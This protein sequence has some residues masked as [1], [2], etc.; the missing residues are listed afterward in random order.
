MDYLLRHAEPADLEHVTEIYRDSVENG[1][2]SYELTP[3]SLTEMAERYSALTNLNYPYV[4]AEASD[5]AIVGYAY[6]GAYRSRPAYR[7]TVE[8]SVYLAP[9]ARGR[10]IG[11]ALL[12]DLVHRCTALGFR[13]MVAVIG[14]G[15]EPSIRMHEA[16]GFTH[17]GVLKATGYKHGNWLDTVM[18]QLQLGDGSG[19]QP[20]SQAYPGTLLA[21]R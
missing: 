8:D 13:Q 4:V 10:G 17:S 5:G 20:N 7:W 19:Q 2:A 11:R 9:H 6:A 1:V 3:P 18:M 21:P 15:H 14:G 16:I 12:G